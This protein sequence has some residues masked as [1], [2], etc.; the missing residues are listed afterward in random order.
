VISSVKHCTLVV[1]YRVCGLWF[2]RF[3]EVW[4]RMPLVYCTVCTY[5]CRMNICRSYPARWLTCL[6]GTWSIF[7]VLLETKRT[8][9][10]S[11]TCEQDET[12]V[13]PRRQ[14][15]WWVGQRWT[16]TA[17]VSRMHNTYERLWCETETKG[18]NVMQAH[19][20]T[21]DHNAKWLTEGFLSKLF[22]KVPDQQPDT[23]W[24][25]DPITVELHKAYPVDQSSPLPVHSVIELR[26][27]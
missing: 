27:G 17:H 24:Q 13:K 9:T 2:C 15:S 25:R 20:S 3:T 22:W 1:L 21:D 11:D 26:G 19:H 23:H 12:G 14:I 18:E 5:M 8:I 7:A 10:T 16:V 4:E 6:S